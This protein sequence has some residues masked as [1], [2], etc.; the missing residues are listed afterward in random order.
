MQHNLDISRSMQSSLPGPVQQPGAQIPTPPGSIQLQSL[1]A[2]RTNTNASSKTIT[3]QDKRNAAW[4]Y[5][6]YD[7]FAD[8]MK[9][10]DDFFIFR[11]FESSNARVILWMQDRIAGLEHRLKT[12]HQDIADS[13]DLNR[14][15]GSLRWD[16]FY[17]PER[18]NIMRELSSTLHHYSMSA[19]I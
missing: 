15:N 4:K 8:W 9:S 19:L 10:E 17:Q 1:N 13:T 3:S 18:D 16:T 5:E 6:G 14:T 2:S 7:A 11:R 12:I